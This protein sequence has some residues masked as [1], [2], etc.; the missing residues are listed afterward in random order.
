MSNKYLMIITEGTNLE[1]AENI[2]KVEKGINQYDLL[3]VIH[4]MYERS[5]HMKTHEKAR[6]QYFQQ[7]V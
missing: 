4:H 7:V 2:V 6:I 5:N 1:S 3:M